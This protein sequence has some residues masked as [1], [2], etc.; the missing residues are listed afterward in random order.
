MSASAPVHPV[1][2]ACPAA[3]RMTVVIVRLFGGYSAL[4]CW[5]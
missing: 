2:C 4:P 3:I 1:R 5:H